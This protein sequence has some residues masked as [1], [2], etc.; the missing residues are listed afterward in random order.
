[1]RVALGQVHVARNRL[2]PPRLHL[3]RLLLVVDI[4]RARHAFDR[5]PLA[6]RQRTIL[7]QLVVNRLDPDVGMDHF[8]RVRVHD[9]R[10]HVGHHRVGD[11]RAEV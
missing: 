9:A 2:G 7:A 8:V 3:C 11:T 5:P 10:R 1:M 4:A 6:R